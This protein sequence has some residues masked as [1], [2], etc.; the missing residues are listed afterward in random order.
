MTFFQ[1]LLL[2]AVQG[3]T[4]WLP[5]SSEGINTLILLYF[6][7]KSLPEAVRI[8]L[9]LHTGTV[10]AALVYFRR[11]I[12]D[13]SRH[14]PQYIRELRANGRT[15]QDA[16]TSFLI[17]STV[18]TGVIGAPLL[19]ILVL[20]DKA[21][22]V[23][24]DLHSGL[25]MA[26]IGILLIITGFVQKYAPRSLGTKTKAGLKD[27]IVLGVVQAF[28]VFPG[29]SR[30]GLTV[31]ALLFRGYDV[32]HAL[33][34]TF[35]MGIPVILAADIGLR[36]FYGVSFDLSAVSGLVTAFL[37]GILTIGV[38]LRIATRLHFWKF[39]FF[40]GGLSLLPLLIESL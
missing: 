20:R 22:P 24:S 14:L 17:V 30:S 21:I 4:E 27:A 34:I 6:Y 38:L 3:I 28:S 35:L 9:Q 12:V 33:R 29:L 13:L 5:I 39:C 7:Q 2:G 8:S 16:L 25:V 23:I 15:E 10:L 32:K 19:M 11:D 37:F 36:L 40:L 18:L 31:S 1:G 26:I